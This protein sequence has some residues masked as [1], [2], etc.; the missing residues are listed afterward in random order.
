LFGAG[1]ELGLAGWVGTQRLWYLRVSRKRPISGRDLRRATGSL[2]GRF[3]ALGLIVGIPTGI[4]VAV[5]A[6]AIPTGR[7]VFLAVAVFVIDVGL[8]FTPPALCFTTNDPVDALRHG[9][10]LLR[11]SW[12]GCAFYALTP[13]LTLFVLTQ[14]VASNTAAGAIATGILGVAASMLGLW[15][16]GPIVLFYLRRVPVIGDGCV[17]D[18]PPPTPRRQPTRNGRRSFLGEIRRLG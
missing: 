10:R 14:T 8:T 15:L 16:K 11:A 13:P 17:F 3:L 1:P 18:P 2:L 7:V 12:P 9:W 6:F 5:L 4:I